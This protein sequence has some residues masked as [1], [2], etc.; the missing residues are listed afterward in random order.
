MAIASTAG[1]GNGALAIR[2]INHAGHWHQ[3]HWRRRAKLESDVV[4]DYL[5]ERDDAVYGQREIEGDRREP[6]PVGRSPAGEAEMGQ[7][8]VLRDRRQQHVRP[9]V[10]ARD[11]RVEEQLRGFELPE[12]E[13]HAN[14][15]DRQGDKRFW[16]G[17]QPDFSFKPGADFGGRG[18][19]TEPRTSPASAGPTCVA[20]G[21][22]RLSPSSGPWRLA[23]ASVALASAVSPLPSWRSAWPSPSPA[24]GG[25]PASSSA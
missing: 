3:D 24:D 23:V 9:G 6:V 4:A 11:G 20:S 7:A 15:D 22:W 13:P 19:A 14:A 10:T 21:P 1:T 12:D 17:E 8:L 18:G 5:R 25:E 2:P 16:L